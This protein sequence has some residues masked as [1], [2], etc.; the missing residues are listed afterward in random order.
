MWKDPIVKEVRE[1]GRKL[2]KKANHDLHV[3][4]KNLRKNE[5]DL[6]RKVV[7]KEE[8]KTTSSKT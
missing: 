8:K 5:Q 6:K 2:E 4:F 3:F 7:S 1:A